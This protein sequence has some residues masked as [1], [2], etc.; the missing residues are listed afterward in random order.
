MG[1]HNVD[2]NRLF[3]VYD[4]I[5]LLFTHRLRLVSQITAFQYDANESAG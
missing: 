4:Y 3:I 2:G 5:F 1:W